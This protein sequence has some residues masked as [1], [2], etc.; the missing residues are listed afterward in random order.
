MLG[1]GRALDGDRSGGRV[2]SAALGGGRGRGAAGLGGVVVVSAA[3]DDGDDQ[4]QHHQHGNHGTDDH[5]PARPAH[6]RK[7]AT[8]ALDD[9]WT[10]LKTAIENTQPRLLTALAVR[11]VLMA[12][13]SRSRSR[14]YTDAARGCRE[15][16]QTG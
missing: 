3:G 6:A 11:A 16:T 2:A 4:R 14:K 8:Q 15:G 5:R 9:E 13:L 10:R 1:E 7:E 12:H